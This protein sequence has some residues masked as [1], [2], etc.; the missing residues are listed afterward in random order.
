MVVAA[1]WTNS[2]PQQSLD[3]RVFAEWFERAE[4]F[5]P[6]PKDTRACELFRWFTIGAHNEFMGR[7][8]ISTP[9]TVRASEQ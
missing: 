6:N 8:N 4:G 7:L 2:G 5:A 1:G 9:A 3:W